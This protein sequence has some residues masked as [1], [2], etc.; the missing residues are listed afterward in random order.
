MAS[1]LLTFDDLSRV[2][3][4]PVCKHCIYFHVGSAE[5]HRPPDGTTYSTFHCW[6]KPASG[7]ED[8]NDKTGPE[9]WCGHGKWLLDFE[10][11]D[12]AQ[13]PGTKPMTMANGD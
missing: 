4:L 7:N 13:K 9:A 2:G 1:I 6:Y 12:Y 11:A 10:G 5:A 8:D 3:C